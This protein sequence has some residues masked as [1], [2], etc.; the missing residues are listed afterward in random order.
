MGYISL[1]SI[2][3]AIVGIA[4]CYCAILK[5]VILHDGI[6]IIQN[7]VFLFSSNKIT[8]SCFFKKKKKLG[9]SQPCWIAT[10]CFMFTI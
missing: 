5:I 10:L 4:S 1:P 2:L 8:K 3:N 7:G 6:K 9:F